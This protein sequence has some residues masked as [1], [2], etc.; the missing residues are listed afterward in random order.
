LLPQIDIDTHCGRFKRSSDRELTCLVAPTRPKLAVF[1]CVDSMS[2]RRIV[3]E[4]VRDRAALHVDGRMAGETLRVLCAADP[5]GH[6]HYASTLFDDSRAH[7]AP[8]TGRS[9]LYAASIAA[10]L[11]LSRF[12]LHLRGQASSRDVL[13]QLAGDELAVL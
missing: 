12:A 10:G 7:P 3:W 1:C 8:C 5:G 2:G 4:T 9:T 13:L 11:M 6:D